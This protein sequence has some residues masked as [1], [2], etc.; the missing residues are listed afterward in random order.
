M[1]NDQEQARAITRS[2][3]PSLVEASRLDIG[4]LHHLP[5]KQC[6]LTNSHLITAVHHGLLES[7]TMDPSWLQPSFTT[8]DSPSSSTIP[9]SPA[10]QANK[11]RGA[12][13]CGCTMSS[14]LDRLHASPWKEGSGCP[15]GI[16]EE[17]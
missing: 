6:N 13:G 9:G 17:S 8:W 14:S 2:R 3:Y 7:P 11:L 1:R 10:D 15:E 16:S 4:L 5:P 12:C